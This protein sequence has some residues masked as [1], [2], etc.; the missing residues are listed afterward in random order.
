[1]TDLVHF[2]H[3]VRG[4]IHHRLVLDRLLGVVLV[5]PSFHH[6]GSLLLASNPPVVFLCPQA[7]TSQIPA[8]S[9]YL[10][11]DAYSQLL[12]PLEGRESW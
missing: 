12:L 5:A 2:L 4:Q 7:L 6:L 9:V 1:M 3:L 8:L 11:I 10:S